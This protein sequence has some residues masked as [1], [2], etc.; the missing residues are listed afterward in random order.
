[1]G[2]AQLA[3]TP[4]LAGEKQMPMLDQPDTAPPSLNQEP[5]RGGCLRFLP[6]YE[7]GAMLP[8]GVVELW[9]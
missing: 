9:I 6:T 5:F 4:A 3:L 8:G 7:F 1:M 2:G